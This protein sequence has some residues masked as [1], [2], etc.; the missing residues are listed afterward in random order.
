MELLLLIPWRVV[1]WQGK[2]I[3]EHFYHQNLTQLLVFLMCREVHDEF[4]KISQKPIGN[5]VIASYF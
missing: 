2:Y 5:V 4:R 1:R 3:E